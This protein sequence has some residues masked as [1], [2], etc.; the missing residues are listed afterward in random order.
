MFASSC[1][2]IDSKHVCERYS[3]CRNIWNISDAAKSPGVKNN[4][5]NVVHS[6]SL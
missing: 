1:A 6:Y 5:F 3:I 4:E 2:W